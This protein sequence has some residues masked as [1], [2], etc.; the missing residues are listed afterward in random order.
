MSAEKT[1]AYSALNDF[2]CK[3]TPNWVYYVRSRGLTDNAVPP[4]TRSTVRSLKLVRRRRFFRTPE[5]RE[6]TARLFGMVCSAI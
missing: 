5:H 6:N 4:T 2:A 1:E 3:D